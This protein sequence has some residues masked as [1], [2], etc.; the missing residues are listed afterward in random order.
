MKCI[1][2]SII[3]CYGICVAPFFDRVEAFGAVQ[4]PQPRPIFY[5][6]ITQTSH[7]QLYTSSH[8]HTLLDYVFLW[9]MAPE[10]SV[11]PKGFATRDQ[12][13]EALRNP[14]AVL[15]DARTD[16]EIIKDGFLSVRGHRWVHASCTIEDCPLL[17]KTA[18]S[19]LPDK[20]GKRTKTRNFFLFP[21]FELGRSATPRGS[22]HTLPC[23]V[24]GCSPCACILWYGQTR[25]ASC[26]NAQKQRLRQ[27]V[28]R[29]CLSRLGLSQSPALTRKE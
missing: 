23:F 19:Q 13:Q 7:P 18:E 9:A 14:Q 6:T 26:E 5:N 15:L 2:S 20:N 21:S 29:W 3:F 16:E 10:T 11:A 4:L 17:I 8:S 24:S 25:S 1:T 27:C 12:V 22:T 28:E